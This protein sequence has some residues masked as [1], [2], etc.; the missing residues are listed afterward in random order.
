METTA[1]TKATPATKTAGLALA[2]V[3]QFM[4][5][6]RLPSPLAIRRPRH[7]G[8]VQ[9]VRVDLAVDDLEAWVQATAGAYESTKTIE[10]NAPRS[11]IVTFAGRV[12][13]PIG[14]VPVVLRIV[15]RLDADRLQLVSGGAA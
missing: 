11:V 1:T 9:A 14:E 10:A 7:A 3:A 5:D 15:Q 2:A 12:S 8:A 4:L 13:S 6:Q